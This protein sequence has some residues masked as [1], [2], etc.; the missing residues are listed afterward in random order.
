[1]YI[2]N[3]IEAKNIWLFIIPPTFEEED[4]Y[5]FANVDRSAGRSVCRSV[6]QMVF[7]DYLKYHLSVFIFHM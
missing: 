5:C 1:M 3:N 6:D 2:S 4:V 7:T